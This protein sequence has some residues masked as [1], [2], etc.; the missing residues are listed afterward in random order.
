MVEQEPCG[1]ATARRIAEDD[2]DQV[3]LGGQRRNALRLDRGTHI[4][5]AT[6]QRNALLIGR[7]EVANA[8]VRSRHDDGSERGRKDEAGAI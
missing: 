8:G 7:A 3:A 4:G 5:D 1:L 6:V 2:G